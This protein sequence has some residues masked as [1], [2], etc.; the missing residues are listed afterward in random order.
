MVIL[1]VF[2][3]V[4]R[5]HAL[6]DMFAVNQR[7]LDCPRTGVYFATRRI[8]L[9]LI[10]PAFSLSTTSAMIAFPLKMNRPRNLIPVFLIEE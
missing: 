9:R 6:I 3:E 1:L 5:P 2:I 8:R 7:Y 10:D 4:T